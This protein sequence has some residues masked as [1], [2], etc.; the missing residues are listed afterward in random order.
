MESVVIY[1]PTSCRSIIFLLYCNSET[2]QLNDATPEYKRSLESV[3]KHYIFSVSVLT[4][5]TLSLPLVCVGI[6]H[7][8]FCF[9]VVFS[10]DKNFK[11]MVTPERVQRHWKTNV[12]W[13]LVKRNAVKNHCLRSVMRKRKPLSG[14]WIKT[15]ALEA[16]GTW[17]IL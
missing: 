17:R 10:T 1:M 3:F 12:L 16:Q 2:Q 7:F 11:D 9:F 14:K 6:V 5:L 8:G 15:L 13:I 4:L